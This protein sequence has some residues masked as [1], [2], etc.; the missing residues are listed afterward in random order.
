MRVLVTD[1]NE[2][3]ALAVTRALGQQGLQV[4]IGAETEHSLAAASK[5][6]W[7]SFS[8]PSPYADAQGTVAKILDVVKH[9]H[10][11]MVFPTSD[12][13]MSL[14]A[15]RRQEFKQH[16]LL[17]IP[18]TETF[19]SLSNKYRLMQLAAELG[20]P[21]PE[22]AFVPDGRLEG[23]VTTLRDFPL[24]V[25]PGQSV[26]KIN[27]HLRKTGVHYAASEAELKRLYDTIDYLRQPSLIQRRVE[28]EGQGVFALMNHGQPV[29]LF[30]HRRLREKPPSGGV[31]VLRESIPLP[32]PMTEYALRLLQNA[33]WHGVA[34]VEFKIDRQT[35]TPLLMEVNGRFW[36]SLQ[37][38]ID[39]GL[40]FP[41]LLY[42]LAAGEPLELPRN[43]YRIGVKSRWLLGDVDHLIARLL[44]SDAEL[45]L[46]PNS[47]TKLRTL[48][49]FCRFYER[50]M[51]NE[52]LRFDDPRPFAYE[53]R[54]Y[55]S[56]LLCRSARS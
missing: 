53:L 32:Q 19:E 38:A 22:T 24:V 7:Q 28:G 54:R 6:C 45:S 26:V 33:G 27:G 41:Y 37:L 42:Q 3:S 11:G 39:A 51:R 50:G 31:S 34:M 20:I 23:V 44:K 14:I 4:V 13:A 17:P 36:G 29:A 5:Y 40:N 16:S 8:Y 48:L 49:E 15:Q 9:L 55:V 30:A 46:P 2:R 21:I 56:A 52:V 1:G 10:V 18:S 35:R 43:G 12:I 25:K 47:P